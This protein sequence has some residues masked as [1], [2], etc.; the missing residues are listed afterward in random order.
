MKRIGTSDARRHL[1]RLLD[2]VAQGESVTITRYGKP[3]AR[4]VPLTHDRERAQ[5]AATRIIE[6]R[7]Q[8]MR[9]P[10]ADLVATIHEGHS[11]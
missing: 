1:R 3:L 11:Q 8:L 4:L 10:L 2:R 9:A 6:R 5:K 7:Q